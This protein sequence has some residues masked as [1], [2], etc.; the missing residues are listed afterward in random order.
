MDK[1]FGI[2]VSWKKYKNIQKHMKRCSTSLVI[3][4]VS[5]NHKQVVFVLTKMAKKE[6]KKLII[7]SFDDGLEKLHCWREWRM[8]YPLWKT[9]WQFLKNVKHIPGFPL[10]DMYSRE[11]KMHFMQNFELRFHSIIHNKK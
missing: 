3:R 8:I 10:L 11:R 2:D 4:N 5:H 1:L 7:T 9:V 6:K